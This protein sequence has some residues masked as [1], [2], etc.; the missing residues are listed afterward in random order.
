MMRGFLEE[1]TNLRF[2]ADESQTWGYSEEDEVKV[3][4]S[5]DSELP[6]SWVNKENYLWH[7]YIVSLRYGALV[8]DLFFF[9]KSMFAFLGGKNPVDHSVLP[10]NLIRSPM[11]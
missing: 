2:C 5:M 3:M 7:G 10:T 4:F 8:N 6:L 1:L 9:A 11:N